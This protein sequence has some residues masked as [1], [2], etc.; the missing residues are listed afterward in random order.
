MPFPA[1]L[2]SGAFWRSALDTLATI[3][4]IAVCAALIWSILVEPRRSNQAAAPS[5]PAPPRRPPEPPLPVNPVSL[6]DAPLLGSRSAKIALIIYSDFQCPFCKRFAIDTFPKIRQSYVDSGKV[7]I[8]FRHVPLESIHPLAVKA[9]QSAVCADRQGKFWEMHDQLFEN[10]QELDEPGLR[11]RAKR[12]GLVERT[13]DHCLAAESEARVREDAGEA[14]KL[15]V[16]VTPTF[17]VGSVQPGGWVKVT[18]RFSG[19]GPVGQFESAL[20]SVLANKTSTVT[21]QAR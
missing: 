11:A 19:A 13:F 21:Q 15:G 6:A 9:A 18:R 8:A 3:A 16:S 14:R 4:F 1:K 7:L 2:K 20:E 12:V 5:F 10:Q 17:F